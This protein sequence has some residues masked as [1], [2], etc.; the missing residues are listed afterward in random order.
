MREQ[1]QKIPEKIKE[2]V[3]RCIERIQ[4]EGESILMLPGQFAAMLNVCMQRSHGFSKDGAL[5]DSNFVEWKIREAYEVCRISGEPMLKEI[6]LTENSDILREVWRLV[7]LVCIECRKQLDRVVFWTEDPSGL[8]LMTEYLLAEIQR[9]AGKEYF[10][11]PPAVAELMVKLLRPGLDDAAWEWKKFWDPA[12]G[13]GALLGQVMRFLKENRKADQVS[14]RGT[15][16]SGRM[17]EIAGVSLWIQAAAAEWESGWNAEVTENSPTV[18]NRQELPLLEVADALKVEDSFDYIVANPP[19]VSQAAGEVRGHIVPTKVL[20]LQFLQHIMRSLKQK[21]RAAV[22]VNEGLLFG[23][24]TAE[25]AIRTE[26]VE[27]HGLRAVISLPQGT[28]A[29]YTNAKVSI[30][31]FGGWGEASSEVFFY[32]ALALGYTLNKS[33]LPQEE[34]DIPDILEKDAARKALYANWCRAKER[35][36]V[37]NA[38]GVPVPEEWRESRVCFAD[39]GQLRERDY[40]LLPGIWQ[41][42]REES[43]QETERPEELFKELLFLEQQIQ[44]Y[45]ERINDSI[46]GG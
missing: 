5:E 18:Q 15:D 36:T 26:L 6:V 41:P 16:I 10:F 11:T 21:G 30:L 3:A 42:K 45:L 23:E 27:R 4:L 13:S 31:L 8:R 17:V 43:E 9:A 2:S 28:F 25:R 33:R 22:L 38:Y 29:P 46:Y 37:Y 1:G 14:L 35:G 7:E 24:R 34:N 32:E 39:R 20:H 44:E 40:A 19:V 12:C